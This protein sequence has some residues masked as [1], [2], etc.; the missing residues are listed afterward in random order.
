MATDTRP[1]RTPEQEIRR[2]TRRAFLTMGAGAVGM[3]A[4]WR[5]LNSLSPDGDISAPL[6]KVLGFNE[7][8][9]RTTL[10]GDNHLVKTYPAS[11]IRHL[12]VNGE[13]GLEQPLDAAGWNLEV[14]PVSGT[15]L[16]L[17]LADVQMPRQCKGRSALDQP[18][19]L[20]QGAVAPTC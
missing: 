1:T 19:D 2:R 10:F 4:V 6:R 8:V 13:F 11:A 7:R 15:S 12:K 17:A 20:R 14:A 16:K 9:V 5:W 18:L 3:A